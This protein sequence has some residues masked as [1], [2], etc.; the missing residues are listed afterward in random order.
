[1]SYSV[2]GTGLVNKSVFQISF[3]DCI[4]TNN[5]P[6]YHVLF[7]CESLGEGIGDWVLFLPQD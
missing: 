5:Q 6:K 4:F 3:Q 1:M 7:S 2:Y